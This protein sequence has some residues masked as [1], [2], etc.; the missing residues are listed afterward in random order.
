MVA[1]VVMDLEAMGSDMEDMEA[2]ECSEDTV[3]A[4]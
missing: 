1:T 2:M 3:G 4:N